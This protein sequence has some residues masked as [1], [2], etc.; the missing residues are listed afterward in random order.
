MKK[1]G[2]FFGTSTG[3]TEHVAKLLGKKLDVTGADIIDVAKADVA[4][5][6][7]YDVLFFGSSTQGYGDLQDDWDSFVEKVKKVDLKDK[8]VAAFGLGDS[9]SFSDTFCNAMGAIAAAAQDA[10]ATLIGNKVD[11][12][13]YTFEESQSVV[14]GYFCGLALD[15]ANESDQ[16]ESRIDAWLNE[17]K[18]E[19]A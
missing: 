11:T 10:G 6:N 15:E 1:I 9:S 17:L 14:D 16:T 2:I 7:K 4:Q 3:E 13:D 8:K 5:L 18:S 19:L 12:A